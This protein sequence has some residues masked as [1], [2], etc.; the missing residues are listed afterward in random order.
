MMRGGI[1]SLASYESFDQVGEGTYG[2]VYRARDRRSGEAVALKRLIVHKENSGFP[3]C[4]VRE[5]KFLKSLHHKNIVRLK[6]IAT[7][8]GC[9]HLDAD[10]KPDASKA[11]VGGPPKDQREEAPNRELQRCGNLYLVFEYI[12]HD[13]GGLIDAKYKFPPRAV[14]CIMKQLLEVLDFLNE[15]KIMHRDIK[16]SNI[17]ISNRH[18]VKLADFGLA[19]S[20]LGS[21]GREGRVDLTNNVITM[22]YKPPELLLGAQRYSHPVDM[23][24]TGCVLAELE[25]GRPLFPGK[26]EAEQLDLICKV[27]GTP[28]D[29][30]WPGISSMSNYDTILKAIPK[31]TTTIRSVYT[32]RISEPVLSFLERILVADPSGRPSPRVAL[33]NRFFNTAPLP[34]AD[35][36]ELEPLN[37]E[38]GASLHEFQTKQKRRQKEE[39]IKAGRVAS[40]GAADGAASTATSR[41]SESGGAVG[42][43]A[44]EIASSASAASAMGKSGGSESGFPG[45]VGIQPFPAIYNMAAAA[46]AGV[47]SGLG[48]SMPLTAGA[49]PSGAAMQMPMTMAMAIPM[50]A[51]G[52]G[53]GMMMQQQQPFP[54]GFPGRGPPGFPLPP[55]PMNVNMPMPMSMPMQ[56]TGTG[57]GT[58]TG[59]GS[60]PGMPHG[61]G[62]F[63]MTMAPNAPQQSFPQ[64]PFPPSS[65]NPALAVAP[66]QQ[67]QQQNNMPFPLQV[68]VFFFFLIS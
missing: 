33:G 13:L 55:H 25:L 48:P 49:L 2:Y 11:A 42:M 1:G 37:L 31:Y 63:A 39:D 28:D 10:V 60:A 27:I 59:V 9:E 7:S 58:S 4:A 46:A 36:V 8:K 57:T 64:P 68:R 54:P 61:A 66:P 14:K 5:I 12:E 67:Q 38:P 23:W 34:P 45:A 53:M 6:D 15:K 35:P 18:Q 21:D 44:D 17:L 32:G 43:G 50:T 20:T 29:T 24:S 30:V 41:K 26:T 47:G 65:A 19:R 52:Q 51:A 62:N 16:S 40:E 22:W 3:L 56:N